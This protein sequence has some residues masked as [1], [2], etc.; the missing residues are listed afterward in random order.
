MNDF[1][2]ATAFVLALVLFVSTVLLVRPANG[3]RPLLVG[4]MI[5]SL[6]FLY[7]ACIRLFSLQAVTRLFFGGIFCLVILGKLWALYAAA[8]HTPRPF[9]LLL[10]R[11]FGY[12]PDLD[13]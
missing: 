9:R 8:L 4:F 3:E 11:A 12:N 5:S 10:K 2:N 1:L 7:I 6:F 13:K